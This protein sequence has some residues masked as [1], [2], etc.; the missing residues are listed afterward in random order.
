MSEKTMQ[1]SVVLLAISLAVLSSTPASADDDCKPLTLVASIKMTPSQDKRAEFVPV[2]LS[3]KPKLML[4][5]TGGAFSEITPEAVAELGLSPRHADLLQYDIRGQSFDREVDV[6]PFAIGNLTTNAIGLM[7]ARQA[8]L[9]SDPRI[10]GIIAPNILKMYDIEIDFGSDQLNLLS[11]DHCE[12]KVIY[13]PA[14]AVAVVPVRILSDGHIVLPV[15]LDGKSLSAMLDTGA[16][17]SA[18]MLPVAE[19][20]FGLKTGS[21][22]TPYLHDLEG[23]PG[24]AVYRHRFATLDF[25]GVAV[26]NLAIDIL[27]DFNTDKLSQA[28]ELGTRLGNLQQSGEFPD[29][30][31]GMDVLRHLH[32]YIAYKEQKLYITP[33]SARQAPASATSA[34]ASTTGTH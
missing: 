25:G 4:L 29:M 20:E 11:P 28:P 8:S 18:L 6:S 17:N 23:A 12:G 19:S 27:P 15:Q 7:V 24:A 16:Y 3:G 13:W 10:V 31:I 33:A 21:A 14:A 22:D 2:N 26:A 5:D 34:S 1:L 9:F 30:L 32:V